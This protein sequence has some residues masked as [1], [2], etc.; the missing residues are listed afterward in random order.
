MNNKLDATVF[1]YRHKTTGKIS[2]L[3]LEDAHALD[4]QDDHEHVATIEPRMWIEYH[5]DSTLTNNK[6]VHNNEH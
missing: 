4:G 6:R 3:Y 2:A 1:V 5:Y